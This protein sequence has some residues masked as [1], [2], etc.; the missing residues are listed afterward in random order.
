MTH[1]HTKRTSWDTVQHGVGFMYHIIFA[2]RDEED[3][4]ILCDMVCFMQERTEAMVNSS[5]TSALTTVKLFA[6]DRV[7]NIYL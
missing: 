7:L 2:L 6:W 3:G 1:A 4:K 5:T